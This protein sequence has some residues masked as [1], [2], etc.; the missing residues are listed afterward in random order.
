MDPKEPEVREFHDMDKA[1]SWLYDGVTRALTSRFPL[2]NKTL[3]L[4]LSDVSVEEKPYGLPAQKRALL[5]NQRLNVPVHGTWTLRD[6]ATGAQLDQQRRRVMS[7]PY[8]TGRGTIL[9]SGN[10]YSS[11]S[12]ARLRHGAY[13]RMKASGEP[14]TAVNVRPGTG[15]G[16]NLWMQPDTGVMRLAVGGANIPLYPV[17]RAMGVDDARL[18]R[19]WGPEILAANA[20]DDRTA[21]SK[22][23]AKL[24]GP[25]PDPLT[26]DNPLTHGQ[27]VRD[28]LGAAEV[29]PA[30]IERT[31]GLRGVSRITPDLLVRMAQKTLNLQRGHENPDDRDHPMFARVLSVEDHIPERISLD[32][33]RIARNLLYKAQRTRNLAKMP[34]GALSPYVDQYLLGSRL[35]QPLE[36]TNPLALL[37]QMQRLTKMGEGGIGSADAVT[38]SARDVNTGQVGFIDPVAGPEGGAIGIDTRVAY[39]TMKGRDN[40]LYAEF[41]DVR[42][43]KT[44]LRTPEDMADRVVAFPGEL[45]TD[46]PTVAAISGGKL[47]HVPRDDVDYEVP[48]YAHMNAANANMAPAPTGMQSARA[49]Y[50]GKFWS[51]YMPVA[52]GERPLVDNLMPDGAPATQHYG[53]LVGTLPS[54]VDGEVMVADEDRV[55]VR[56]DQGKTHET[57]LV[58]NFPFNRLTGI[59][60]RPAVKVGDRVA[61]GDRLANSNFTDDQGA[62]RLGTNL[63]TAVVP[64]KGKSFED[65]YVI[66]A[67]AAERL[68][69][70]RLFSHDQDADQG[71]TISRDKHVALFANKYTNDQLAKVDERGLAREGQ[72]LQRGDPMILAVG[73]KMLTA[74]DQQLGN[75]HKALRSAHVD[76]STVWENDY[77]GTVV[78][79]VVLRDGS[80]RVNVVA[81]VPVREADKLA[82]RYGLKGIVGKIV[83]DHEMP[84]NPA[85]NQPYELLLNPMGI[86][87]RVAPAQKVEI[88]LAKLARSRGKPIDIPAE[89]PKE[90]WNVWALQQ[91]KDA[92]LP[93]SEGVYDPLDKVKLEGD[94]YT[95]ETY[96]MPFHHLADKK[97]SYRGSSGGS[98]TMDDQP[99]KGGGPSQQ[100]KRMAQQDVNALLSY[101]AKD[102][103]YDA[104]V[105]RGS[106][107]PEYWRALRLGRPV[108]VPGE[109][110]VY[111]KFLETMKAGGINIAKKGDVLSLMPMTDRDVDGLSSGALTSSASVDSD[112]KPITGGLFDPK[113]TGGIGGRRWSHIQL[114]EPVPNPVFE[115]P[116]RRILG[117]TRKELEGV[118]T[119]QQELGGLTGGRALSAALDKI[120]P[121]AR[122]Q[123]LR[124]L[125]MKRRG[126]TRDDAIKVIGFLQGAIKQGVHPRDWMIT[127]VPVLPPVFRPIARDGDVMLSADM[128]ELYRDVQETSK[129]LTQ[130]SK[131]LP[132][133][134]LGQQRLEL[135]RAVTAATGMGESITPEGQ[136][137]RLKGALWQILGDSP[138]TGLYQSRVLAKPVDAVARGVVAPD[139]DLD[140]DSVGIP[141]DMAWTLFKD[142]GLRTM[143]RRNIPL[144][145]ALELW[146]ARAPQAVDVL[147][148]TM[149]QRPVLLNRAPVWHKNNIVAVRAHRVD[150][151]AIRV[152]PLITKSMT[153]DFDGDQSNIHLPVDERAAAQAWELMRPSRNLFSLTDLRSARHT[154]QQ[155]LALGIYR[156]SAPPDM[157]R[158]VRTFPTRAAA[159]AAYARGEIR[160]NDPITI[161]S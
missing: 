161:L 62:L 38:D 112:L 60:Y 24:A 105:V 154:L 45:K 119:G 1:R 78:D 103:L 97:I 72:V 82:T 57:E 117:L 113:L 146:E 155:E 34:D 102:V 32:A 23:Y 75:L 85:T 3:R 70:Q 96:V 5:M 130:L 56:D 139:P 20:R 94:L 42:T 36:E 13:A 46:S 65:A 54:R 89:A 138:K 93:E 88:L 159:S 44:V 157:A 131:D 30:V 18:R 121:A 71:T 122:V 158:P 61:S 111:T 115:D 149:A 43:G 11:V 143:S 135:Y 39:K 98:Y 68:A 90:G 150:G 17:L 160:T 152:S 101:G 136:A 37:E 87:S 9:H 106:N 51:Q 129:S 48:S 156:A 66:S 141:E 29:D 15:R 73:P 40:R 22:L 7:L 153:M 147:D 114:A 148:E 79:A 31:M 151:S 33:G 133:S 100:A 144:E 19:D 120:D 92:G 118:I 52:N 4:E 67:S 6:K 27:A 109:P 104:H 134:A 41:R 77:P 64:Y 10:E 126:A 124:T 21:V 63:R 14:E 116:I 59:T 80:A 108:P 12:Q 35:T 91:L 140:M 55:V 8:L 132:A 125:A 137:K 74:E 76:R 127:R 123:E 28:L 95:G 128:N 142:L 145:R 99:A 26:A 2:E 81:Q 69:T 50:G 84:V 16:F 53:R 25:R 110:F 49:F 47:Q 83:P 107:N 58:K 86:L